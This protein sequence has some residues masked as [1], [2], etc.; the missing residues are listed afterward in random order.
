MH[1]LNILDPSRD[2]VMPRKI[3]D[4]TEATIAEARRF[5][6]R[7]D[8]EELGEFQKRVLEY[9]QKFSKL[10]ADRARKLT[11]ELISNFGIEKKEAIQV[12]NCMPQTTG[13]LRSVL[14]VKGKIL[15]TEQLQEMLKT[16]DKFREKEKE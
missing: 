7:A 11:G 14:S 6:E 9:T 1:D 16:I 3:L 12:A 10:K 5:L 15:S 4:G 13:E 8:V 2:E